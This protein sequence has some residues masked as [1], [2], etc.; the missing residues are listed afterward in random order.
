MRESSDVGQDDGVIVLLELSRG[1]VTR[2][3]IL[4]C[5]RSEP[6]NCNQIGKEVILDWW[7]VQKHLRLLMR[8]RLVRAMDFGH[9]KFYRLTLK[10]EEALKKPSLLQKRAFE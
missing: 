7:T 8:E 6:K 9:I 3:R 4:V 1:A 10:G 2:K 5:L